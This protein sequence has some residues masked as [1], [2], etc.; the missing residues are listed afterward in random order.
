MK[1]SSVIFD[2]SDTLLLLGNGGKDLLYRLTGSQ[3]KSEDM[4]ARMFASSVWR[5]YD[6]GRISKEAVESNLLSRL[7]P[8][9]RNIGKQYLAQWLDSYTVIDGMD[10]LIKDLKAAGAKL[11]VLSDFPPCFET[12]WNRFDIFRYF[13]GR[14]VSYEEGI[15]KEDTRLFE[16][17]LQ[18]YDLRAEDC[19]FVDDVQKNVDNGIKV[20][21]RGHLFTDA[22]KLRKELAL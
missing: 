5:E 3:E 11:F 21:I 14:V 20:G 7:L 16:I 6:C 8:E 15:R 2:C 17:L 13:D 22:E 1:Y 9:D 12:L 10:D 19:L 18:R 4:H